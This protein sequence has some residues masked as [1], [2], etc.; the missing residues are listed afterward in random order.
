M[1][2]CWLVWDGEEQIEEF[3]METQHG[4]AYSRKNTGTSKDVK[5]KKYIKYREWDEYVS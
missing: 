2:R 5:K 1:S 3:L 4:R